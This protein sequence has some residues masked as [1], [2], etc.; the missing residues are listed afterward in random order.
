[1]LLALWLVKGQNGIRAVMTVGSTALL[2]MSIYLT[3]QFLLDRAAG[4]DAEMLYTASFV[5]FEPLHIY[6]S[7]GVDGISVA[8]LLL[9]GIIVFTGTFVSWDMCKE[10]FLW[11]TLLS[12]GV[13]GF[14]ISFFDY[15]DNWQIK[16]EFIYL[17]Y[18][19]CVNFG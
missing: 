18:P 2:G 4:A 1:M 5:W 13:F 12:L 14:F 7:V 10:Y 9:S 6:Y 11:F 3:V 15:Y 16:M 19:V 8:M 17:F